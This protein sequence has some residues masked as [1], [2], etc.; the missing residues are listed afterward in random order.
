[1]M[2]FEENIDVSLTYAL[3]V[4]LQKNTNKLHGFWYCKSGLTPD[5]IS[6]AS[7]K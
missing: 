4:F 3:Q 7:T 6:G 1:M 5:A 2:S